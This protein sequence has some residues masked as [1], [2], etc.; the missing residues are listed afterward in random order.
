MAM[1]AQSAR[2]EILNEEFR[3]AAYDARLQ[4]A[5]PPTSHSNKQTGGLLV[6]TAGTT[7]VC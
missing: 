3:S 2:K 5:F 7:G 6:Q 4:W 1:A